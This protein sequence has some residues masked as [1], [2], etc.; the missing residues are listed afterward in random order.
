MSD[1][2][3]SNTQV[4][5]T[6]QDIVAAL[7]QRELKF[8]SKLLPFVTDVSQFCVKGAKT[9]SFPRLASFTA[10]DRASGVQ[11]DASVILSAVDQLSLDQAAYVAYIVDSQ[12]SI[13]SVL[14]WDLECAKRAASA[15]A[16]YVDTT[17]IAKMESEGEATT[18]V[19]ATIT[20]AVILEMRAKYLRQDGLLEEAVLVIP[21]EQEKAMLALS[22]F[23]DNQI[24]GPGNAIPSGVIGKVF[25]IPV[26]IHNGITDTAAYYLMGKS[27]MAIGFQ[28]SPM[29]SEQGANE[30][31]AGAKRVAVDQLFGVKGLQI[32]VN[33]AA[34]GKSA[35]IIK[36]N[37][38]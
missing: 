20:A 35:L 24:Y 27:G 17:L 26:L 5:E 25:G 8:S 30:F 28:Q 21:P 3:I 36:D 33:G 29:M 18:T 15:H 12:D 31:G 7:V 1:A 11:G 13:Q 4:T 38:A 22:T 14:A 32:A 6:K 16:R 9:I 2:I 37:N 23:A 19:A 34:S 10:V